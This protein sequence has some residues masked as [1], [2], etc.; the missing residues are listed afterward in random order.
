MDSPYQGVG[1]GNN[2]PRKSEQS[3]EHVPN[4]LRH[5]EYWATLGQLSLVLLCFG[6]TF[7]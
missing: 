5:E 2:R 1:Q 7:T 3:I 4:M 6:Y